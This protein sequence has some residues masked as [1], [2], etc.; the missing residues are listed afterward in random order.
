M[1][2]IL[3]GQVP[4]PGLKEGVQ[5]LRPALHIPDQGGGDPQRATTGRVGRGRVASVRA[6]GEQPSGTRGGGGESGQQDLEEL[7]GGE[8]P[9]GVLQEGLHVLR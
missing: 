1:L 4:D 3:S 5:V 9:A 6:E 2:R 7:R 8:G